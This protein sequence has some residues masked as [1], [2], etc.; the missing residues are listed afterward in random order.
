MA[1][2]TIAAMD[3]WRDDVGIAPYKPDL[4]GC[5]RRNAAPAVYG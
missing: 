5:G 1:V 2:P 4:H 3:S